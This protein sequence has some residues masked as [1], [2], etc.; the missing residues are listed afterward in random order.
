MFEAE[1]I[2]RPASEQER[3]EKLLREL[4]NIGKQL[5]LGVDAVRSGKIPGE[6]LVQGMRA[7]DPLPAGPAVELQPLPT[8]GSF[9]WLG[10]ERA[11]TAVLYC[12]GGGGVS[13]SVGGHRERMEKLGRLCG[14]RIFGLEYRLAPEH[15]FPSDIDDAVAGYRAL[16]A[17]GI[18]PER[19]AFAGDS[20]GGGI[21]L[22]A[23]IRARDL[24]EPLPAAAFLACGVFDRT[25]VVQEGFLER[26]VTWELNDPVLSY[27]PFLRWLCETYLG[28]EDPANPLASPLLAD[29][30][31]LP[32]LFI[33][34]GEKEVLRGQSEKLAQA[35][36]RAGGEATLDIVT[37]MFHNFH[38]Y[39]LVAARA[40]VERAAEFLQERLD[41]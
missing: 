15:P 34:A 29:L 30:S 22:A 7:Q 16:L 32:P 36:W 26:E 23:L 3:L 28:G 13:G 20:H 8:G 24:G 35:V 6:V 11:T 40:A 9:A 19:I 1:N 27:G 4:R 14:S 17:Q 41:P 21:A 37:D 5:R 31:G 10:P 12:H 38:A 18:P 39:P 2:D 33:Q 25:V